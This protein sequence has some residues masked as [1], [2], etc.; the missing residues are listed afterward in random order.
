MAR[1]EVRVE[2]LS[3]VIEVVV[4]RLAW[5]ER[6]IRPRWPA[7]FQ[8]TRRLEEDGFA[9]LLALSPRSARSR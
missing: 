4:P 7:V 1:R 8:T 6:P 5:A 9:L 2:Q 3:R